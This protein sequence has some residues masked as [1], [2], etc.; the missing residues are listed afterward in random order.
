MMIDSEH[1][2]QLIGQKLDLLEQLHS[3]SGNQMQYVD[4]ENLSALLEVLAA[5][6][7]LLFEIE[8]LDRQI[9]RYHVDDPEDRVWPSQEMRTRCREMVSRCNVLVREALEND[10]LAE[11]QLSR[12]KNEAKQQLL[13]VSDKIRV[14]GAYR[15]QKQHP[16]QHGH[17]HIDLGSG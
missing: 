12:K 7:R 11:Q 6:Q 8:G 5:K 9:T 2:Y 1:L 10:Q 4:S 17:Y 3:C 14:Q 16:A 13:Q 15:Q